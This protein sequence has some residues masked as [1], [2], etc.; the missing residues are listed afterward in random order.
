MTAAATAAAVRAAPAPAAP[1]HVEVIR[2]TVAY[3]RATVI[4][5]LSLAIAEGELVSLLGPSGCGKTT[6]LRLM[7]GLVS[8]RRGR[9]VVAGEDLTDVPVHRRRI[10]VVFQSYALFPNLDVLGNVA[11]GLR[12]AGVDRSEAR[13]RAAEALALV[14]MSDY[15]GRGVRALSGGQQQRVAVARAIAVKPR[16]LLLDEP[17][18]ALDRQLRETM[19]VE[20]RRLLRDLR[21]TAIFVTHDQDEA[22]TLSD[23]V[24][25]MNR[26]RIEQLDTAERVHARPATP[27]VLDFVGLASRFAGRVTASANGLVE[28][29]TAA[30]PVR[31]PGRFLRGSRVVVAARAE[32]ITAGGSAAAGENAV[33][34]DL[35]EIVYRGSRQILHFAAADGDRAVVEASGRREP[36][37]T[38]PTTLRW[39]IDDTLIYPADGGAPD[40]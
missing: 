7:A 39:A 33:R 32:A 8:P 2:A 3:G 30:G 36:P 17:F 14:R 19:Q 20:L 25:V 6:L 18:S 21:I 12:A 4:D 31:A 28:V 29:A 15:A 26:G 13:A 10:G 37:G 9:V 24:A 16:V 38:G 35:A 40:A 1:A 23:R 27:F 11:F 34:L 22:L 5:D